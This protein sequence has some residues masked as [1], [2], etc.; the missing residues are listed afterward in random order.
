MSSEEDIGGIVFNDKAL[1]FLTAISTSIAIRPTAIDSQ[2]CDKT[3][4]VLN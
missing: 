2:M 4:S 1:S 3:V